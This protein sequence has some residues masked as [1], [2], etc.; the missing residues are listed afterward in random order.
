MTVTD[1]QR[2]GSVAAP[3]RAASA[4]DAGPRARARRRRRDH[5]L[6]AAFAAPNFFFL[7]VFAYWPVVYNGYLSLTD[8]DMISPVKKFVGLTNYVD[9]IADPDFRGTLWTTVLFVVGIVAGGMV[10]GLAIAL[11]L[12]QKLRG[13]R[14]VRTLTFAPYVLSGAAVGTLWLFVFDPNY[15]LIR[16]LMAPL[17]LTAPAMMTD[18]KWSLFG[19]VV[20]YLWKNTGFVAVVYLAGLQSMPRDVY[21]AA[22]LDGASAWTRLRRI[23]VPLL[24]PVTFFLLVTSVI[25]TFQAFD[26]I[27]VMTGGGPGTS[28]SILSWFIYDQGFRAFDAGRSA[29]GAMIM[30]VV[31]LLITGLQAR[32]LERKVHYQ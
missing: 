23:T 26:V 32:Y 11:L 15:G 13:T 20:V 2:G 28:T 31:L 18:S 12:N 29:A 10:L 17:G 8:W 24:S 16:P 30:F 1:A 22:A 9:L 5:L 27:A 6:F 4:Q 25:T 21:E 14:V 19:L 7:L 3:P